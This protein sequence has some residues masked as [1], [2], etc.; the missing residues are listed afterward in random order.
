MKNI[1]STSQLEQLISDLKNNSKEFTT[2][3]GEYL[4][5]VVIC[6]R[7]ERIK[8]FFREVP[9]SD[10]VIFENISEFETDENT[11]NEFVEIMNILESKGV[12]IYIVRFE[13]VQL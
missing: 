10:I 8:K 6:G 5:D 4:F 13:T 1:E 9:S 3:D 12:E 11:K 7:G 2:F